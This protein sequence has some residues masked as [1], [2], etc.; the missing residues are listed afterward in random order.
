MRRSHPRLLL[1][2]IC[3]FLIS[4]IVADAQVAPD[5][6]YQLPLIDPY[7]LSHRNDQFQILWCDVG[8]N[9][10]GSI[11]VDHVEQL[12]VSGKNIVG[13]AK[14]G[15][16]IFNTQHEGEAPQVFSTYQKW[17]DGLAAAGIPVNIQLNTPDSLAT[18][19]PDRI[20]RPWNYRVM[21]G[22]FGQSDDTWSLIVQLLGFAL[23][24]LLGCLNPKKFLRGDAVLIGLAVNII[25]QDIIAGG[26]AG[27]FVGYI[28]LP[29]MCCIAGY[30]GS[31]ARKIIN[32]AR[33]QNV[34]TA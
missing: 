12:A 25:G 14:A 6:N 29:L 18:N 19:V 17:Q 8:H 13:I 3:I 20:L 32:P 21:K 10:G 23:T 5:D 9:Y 16:F 24:F 28:G 22:R 27:E 4:T 26:G 15:N 1:A 11:V 31:Q 33:S 7:I 34:T 30:F 2:S